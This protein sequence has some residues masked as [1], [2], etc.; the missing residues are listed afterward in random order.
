[1]KARFVNTFSR[2]GIAQAWLE[3][4]RAFLVSTF[5]KRAVGSG[6]PYINGK[7]IRQQVHHVVGK[8]SFHCLNPKTE[9]ESP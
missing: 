3:A 7:K 2:D 8:I 1:M 9:Q 5:M 4:H 6:L